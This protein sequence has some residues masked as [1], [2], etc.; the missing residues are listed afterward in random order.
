MRPLCAARAGAGNC[1]FFCWGCFYFE[2]FL[3]KR[4]KP[5]RSVAMH[6]LTAVLLVVGAVAVTALLVLAHHKAA[7]G[8]MP[9]ARYSQAHVHAV[10]AAQPA[11]DADSVS[12]DRSVVTHAR[13]RPKAKTD[14][15]GKVATTTTTLDHTPTPAHPLALGRDDS[16]HDV[17]AACFGRGCGSEARARP[18]SNRVGAFAKYDALR[19]T[20]APA[21]LFS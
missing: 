12:V 9:A 20:P 15:F 5:L 10:S 6:A 16:M 4:A 17:G 2:G 8:S 3:V 11:V 18:P 1:L 21:A 7:Q 14:T 19:N 13:A